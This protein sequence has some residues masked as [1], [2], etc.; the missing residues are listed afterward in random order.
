MRAA[1]RSPRGFTLIEVLVVMGIIGV[2]FSIML[3]MVCRVRDGGRE[4]LCASHM[5][6][7][8]GAFL[9]FAADNGGHLPGGLY[10][11]NDGTQLQSDWLFGWGNFDSTPIQGTVYPYLHDPSVYLCPSLD[12]LA[13]GGFAQSNGHFDYASFTCFEGANVANI[14]QQSKLYQLDGT[15]FQFVSTPL[16]AQE[17]PYQFNGYNIEGDHSNVDQMTHIHHG[18]AYYGAIDGSVQWVNEPDV[19]DSWSNGCWQWT[20]FTTSNHEVSLAQYGG[21]NWWSTQ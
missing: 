8:T 16:I 9:M 3:P 18:G 6:Q 5:R 14:N 19:V 15:T 17:D 7:L 12:S 11:P 21:W 10:G 13:A 20:C 1:D 2:L 4:T